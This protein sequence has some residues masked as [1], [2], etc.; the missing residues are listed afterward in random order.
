MS[1]HYA[2]LASLADHEI[3][4]RALERIDLLRQVA[5]HKAA[6]FRTPWAR[7][8]EAAEGRVRLSPHPELAVALRVDYARMLEMYYAPPLPF[9][10]IVERLHGLEGEIARLVGRAADE[11]RSA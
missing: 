2:D 3:G 9:E 11:S 8:E 5:E 6:Y 1:R 10:A 7:Y 4:Q